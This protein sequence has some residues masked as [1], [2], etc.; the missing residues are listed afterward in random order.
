MFICFHILT[1]ERSLILNQTMVCIQRYSR[2][3]LNPARK[4]NIFRNHR[5]N[6]KLKCFEDR[7]KQLNFY[8]RNAISTAEKFHY[9]HRLHH[10]VAAFRL[11]NGHRETCIIHYH[12]T[13]SKCSSSS[14]FLVVVV[15]VLFNLVVIGPNST[16]EKY[17]VTK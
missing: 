14:F 8:R 15:V 12:T 16:S 7:L 17:Q 4:M 9:L 6:L 13:Y 1:T 10:I 2:Q 5:R 11:L 3:S